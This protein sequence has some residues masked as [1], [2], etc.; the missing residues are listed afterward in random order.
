MTNVLDQAQNISGVVSAARFR[1]RMARLE[2]KSSGGER[3][4]ARE[5]L[6]DIEERF[7][8]LADVPVGGAEAFARERGHGTKSRSP[9]EHGARRR[10]A[11]GKPPA[12]KKSS[13]V[14]VEA[15]RKDRKPVPGI[16]PAA[17]RARTS[18]GTSTR[19]APT[20]RVDRAIR[21]TGIPATVDTGG[22]IVMSMLGATIGLSFAWLVLTSAET[23]GSGTRRIETFL[24]ET[25]PGAVGRIL[26]PYEDV[27][28]GNTGTTKS[29]PGEGHTGRQATGRYH[30]RVDRR[31]PGFHP[32]QH[33]SRR[34]K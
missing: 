13:G 12:A 18:R 27:F 7:P 5:A 14:K 10:P 21:R 11:A 29:T 1:D 24:S 3:G 4:A 34:E 6:F 26:N 22:S 32:F 31:T 20:P 28:P 25:V 2:A 8:E 17:R 9:V 19:P 33:T 23:R 15:K 30:G 16:D